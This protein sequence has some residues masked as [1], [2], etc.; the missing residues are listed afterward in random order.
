[1]N[2]TMCRKA[3]HYYSPHHSSSSLHPF[4]ILNFNSLH[5]VTSQLSPPKGEILWLRVPLKI[6][7]PILK[8]GLRRNE[9]FPFHSV[10]NPT[11]WIP[12]CLVVAAMA[13][14]GGVLKKQKDLLLI[15]H[16]AH[17]HNHVNWGNCST[18]RRHQKPEA[19]S[20]TRGITQDPL[21]PLCQVENVNC[22]QCPVTQRDVFQAC[23][24]AAPCPFFWVAFSC[25]FRGWRSP[26]P[27]TPGTQ[28][29][30]HEVERI[31]DFNG[32]R[33]QPLVCHTLLAYI[34]VRTRPA[35]WRPAPV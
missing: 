12:L 11:W 25:D 24:M 23:Q 9:D 4:I 6:Q 5:S 26:A 7:L 28:S 2:I 21:L 31:N 33:S 8:Y 10:L 32:V 34:K 35:V 14:R 29:F 20:Q 15:V 30:S 19:S 1:M 18:E 27:V 13:G 3:H 16:F 17:F 22:F